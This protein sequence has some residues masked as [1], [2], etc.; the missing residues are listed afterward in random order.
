MKSNKGQSKENWNSK[1]KK[2]KKKRNTRKKITEEKDN[3][4][5]KVTKNKRFG[6][7]KEEVA[8]LEK[9]TKK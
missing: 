5:K 2:R 7:E 8:R 3:K 4:N 6:I 1:V 9:K